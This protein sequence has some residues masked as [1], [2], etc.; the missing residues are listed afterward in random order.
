MLSEASSKLT[1]SIPCINVFG[2]NTGS[3][4]SSSTYVS[5]RL[6]RV[7]SVQV[8]LPEIVPGKNATSNAVI[9]SILC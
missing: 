1:I 2:V 4:S 5:E 9:H 3:C 7:S 6:S 8:T